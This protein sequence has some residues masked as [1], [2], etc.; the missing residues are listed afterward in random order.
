MPPEECFLTFDVVL[1]SCKVGAFSPRQAS[2]DKTML[3]WTA[4][5]AIQRA[6]QLSSASDVWSFGVLMW[7]LWSYGET[8]YAQWT[9]AVVAT[10]VRGGKRLT[11]PQSTPPHVHELVDECWA[12]DPLDRSEFYGIFYRLVSIG[13]QLAGKEV[14]TSKEAMRA[15]A[16]QGLV[17][18]INFHQSSSRMSMT[19][20]LV[21]GTSTSRQGK[22]SND[23]MLDGDDDLA[24]YDLADES[25]T[26]HSAALYSLTS[27]TA[28]SHVYSLVTTARSVDPHESESTT[29][30]PVVYSKPSK[31]SK[32]AAA[33]ATYA[34]SEYALASHPGT[35]RAKNDESEYAV[36]SHP[37]VGDPK[38]HESEYA[39][40]SHPNAAALATYSDATPF[41]HTL[42]L[43]RARVPDT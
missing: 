39:P 29:D 6:D 24:L 30:A 35:N 13:K 3:R 7:E 27:N 5:E 4:P 23:R 37:G 32:P 9:D 41:E 14:R 40:A 10:K 16:G 17:T 38:A 26:D 25:G 42:C 18:P 12:R 33:E 28:N 43:R 1:C 20:S 34:E 31:P 21:S 2:D 11:C 8:P 36:A 15:P 19:G 22:A